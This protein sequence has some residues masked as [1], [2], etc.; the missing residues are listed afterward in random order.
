MTIQENVALA[1]L[2]TLKVGGAA[3]YFAEARNE[4][5]AREAVRFAKTRGLP[6]FVL[7]GGSNLVVADAGWPG[8]VLKV[9]IGG[10]ATPKQN[11]SGNAVL[12]SVG[13]G[14]EWDDFVAFAVSQ[15]CAG[16]ECLSGIPGSVGGTPVQNVGA[17]GQDVAETI[18]SVR[19]LDTKGDRAVTLPKPAC[20]FRYRSSIFNREAGAEGGGERGRFIILQVNY[21]LKRGGA[22]AV[23]YA[24]LQKYF[25]GR[26][27]EAK[28]GLS[29]APSLSEVR[30]AVREIRRSKGML[31][32]SGDEDARSVG[33]FFKNPVL[34]DAEF[35]ELAARAEQR[36]LMVPS[37]PAMEAQHKV[38]AAWLVEHSGFAKGFRLGR[39]AISSKHALAL[40]NPGNAPG[41][42]RA[43]DIIE[44]K[45]AI[46]QGVESAWGIRLIAEPVLVGF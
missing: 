4:D 10:I 11:A 41:E 18:E 37:Y 39:A 21:R 31:I 30:E 43:A 5:D 20:G 12:F 36:G 45:D 27:V 24:D 13:A 33:S 38:S 15:N 25:E 35:Q 22:A 9:A 14:V 8:L 6:L 34:S 19:A 44:L 3:R 26:R 2:T 46:Q 17:Y 42:A 23:K 32:V 16:I 1:P 29:K 28:A 7:G 40:I